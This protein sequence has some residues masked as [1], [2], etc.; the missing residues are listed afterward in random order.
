MSLKVA[1]CEVEPVDGSRWTVVPPGADAIAVRRAEPSDS[2]AVVAMHRRCSAETLRRRYF[3]E[4]PDLSPTRLRNL[5]AND[6]KRHSLVAVHADG[7]VV[8]CAQLH[9]AERDTAD[10][11]VL[12]EDAHQCRGIGSTLLGIMATLG[13]ASGV[14]VL[15]GMTQPDNW[16]LF[17][18]LVRAG[19]EAEL[20][21][22]GDVPVVTATLSAPRG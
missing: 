5:L 4:T 19:L 11:A 3:T 16:R 6:P 15:R 2:D 17:G 10:V 7:N 21:Y 12:V 1:A 13:T 14:R 8:G 20:T 22:E 18:A 9:V